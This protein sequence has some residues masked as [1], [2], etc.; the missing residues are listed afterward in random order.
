LQEPAQLTSSKFN[1]YLEKGIQKSNCLQQNRGRSF[2]KT[3]GAKRKRTPKVAKDIFDRP[4]GPQY[5]FEIGNDQ[6]FSNEIRKAVADGKLKDFNFI[7]KSNWSDI[8]ISC[9]QYHHWCMDFH[10][11]KM[12]GGAGG[13]GQIFN[14]G[15]SKA[16][17]LTKNRC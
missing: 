3:G 14:I 2:L 16:K 1:G 5:T 8:I 7:A 9:L 10:N 15:K 6:I 13:G 11:E 17:L 12:S 4:N